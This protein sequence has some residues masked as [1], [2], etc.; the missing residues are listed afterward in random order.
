MTNTFGITARAF[1]W[2]EDGTESGATA[3]AAENANIDRIESLPNLVLRYGVQESGAGSASGASTDDYQLQY[4][5]NGG[6]YTNVTTSSSVCRGFGSSN[7]TDAGS[8]TQR[9]TSGTGSFIA[10]EISEDGLLDDWQLTANNFSELL[11]TVAIQTGDTAPD[12]TIDFRVLRNGGV[13]NTYSVTPRITI[14]AETSASAGNSA[15]T[16]AAQTATA[17]GGA[18]GG[19]ASGTGAANAPSPALHVNAGLASGTGTA[20]QPT[21]ETLIATNA[22]AELANGTGAAQT[23]VASLGV[24]AGNAAGTGAANAPAA[25]IGPAAGL[26]AGTGAAASPAAAV[27]GVSGTATGTGEAS[28]PTPALSPNAAIAAGLAAAYDG[29]GSVGAMLGLAAGTGT[30]HDATVEVI[31]FGTGTEAPAGLASGTGQ[32]YDATVELLY[33]DPAFQADAFQD[34]AF[35]LCDQPAPPVVVETRTAG[36][37]RERRTAPSH[38]AARVTNPAPRRIIE[39]SAPTPIPTYVY[40]YAGVAQGRGTAHGATTTWNDDETALTLLL[41]AL[42]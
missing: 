17:S 24:N 12:N 35:Q 38:E 31:E 8:T 29:T 20:H 7:L 11:Y 13:F 19:L 30:A 16:G 6:A 22:P 40:A 26:A 33:C 39:A 10:G 2:Y 42:V 21:V 32:A 23:A 4:S 37:R 15:G 34:D 5:L 27:S 36:G 18:V 14:R 9:L 25:S 1:R 41:S 28:A 3:I